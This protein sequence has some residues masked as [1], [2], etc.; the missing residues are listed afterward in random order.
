MLWITYFRGLRFTYAFI[1]ANIHQQ[2]KKMRDTGDYRRNADVWIT[3]GKKNVIG[4]EFKNMFART[5]RN[6]SHRIGFISV[7]LNIAGSVES[8][9]I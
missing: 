1:F 6:L 2:A 9:L 5:R 7:I 3:A 8:K 4:G